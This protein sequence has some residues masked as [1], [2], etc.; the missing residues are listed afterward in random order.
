MSHFYPLFYFMIIAFNKTIS[1]CHHLLCAPAQSLFVI[2]F[3][4]SRISTYML[5]LSHFSQ[6]M[7]QPDH[8]SARMTQSHIFI[9]SSTQTRVIMPFTHPKDRSVEQ[10][11]AATPGVLISSGKTT[12]CPALKMTRVAKT[13]QNTV[14]ITAK[15]DSLFSICIQPMQ[16][17]QSTRPRVQRWTLHAFAKL[18]DRM[19]NRRCRVARRP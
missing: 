10:M 4:Y 19:L 7:P 14:S 17:L 13:A 5:L 16:Y 2:A 12:S 15:S 3:N 11:N 8:L 1:V 18:G 6:Q 9:F